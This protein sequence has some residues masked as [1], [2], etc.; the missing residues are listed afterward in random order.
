MEVPFIDDESIFFSIE[1]VSKRESLV[2][3]VYIKRSHRH[4]VD[5]VVEL[6]TR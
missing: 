4:A 3:T 1:R 2:M 5:G 6:Q